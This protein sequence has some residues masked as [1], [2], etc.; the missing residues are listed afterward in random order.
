MFLID[1]NCDGSKWH[2]FDF[3]HVKVDV[4]NY[5]EDWMVEGDYIEY[6]KDEGDVIHVLVFN[7]QEEPTNYSCTITFVDAKHLL[8]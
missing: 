5:L 6:I 4:R 1:G 8:G 7:K 2:A 3:D